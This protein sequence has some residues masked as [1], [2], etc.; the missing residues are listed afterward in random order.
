MYMQH[1][2][3]CSGFDEYNSLIANQN[4]NEG[5]IKALHNE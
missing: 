3:F 4:D 2:G 5:E 1:A